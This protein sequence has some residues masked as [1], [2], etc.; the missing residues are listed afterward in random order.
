MRTLPTWLA[1]VLVLLA[2]GLARFD[3]LVVL[4]LACASGQ[5]ELAIAHADPDAGAQGEPTAPSTAQVDPN[6][7]IPPKL[8]AF[9][10]AGYPEDARAAGVSEASVTL[11]LT[12]SAEGT[13]EDASLSGTPAG[14]GFDE[15]AQSAA[16]GFVF[17]P[18]MKNGEP[19]RARI[20]YR[21]EF[22]LAPAEAEVEAAAVEQPIA[23]GGLEITIKSERNKPLKDVELLISTEADANFAL[24]L[25]TNEQGSAK[26]GQLQP[27]KYVVHISK[28]TYKAEA[29]PEEVIAGQV[30]ALSYRLTP[31]LNYEEYSATARVKAPPRE[32]TR[33]TIEREVL[34]R[35]A[36]TRGDALRTIELLP[37]VGRPP[38]GAGLVL[39]R[40][41]APQDSSVQL[42]GV[43]VPLLY[44]FGLLTSFINSRALERI[45][46]YPGNFSVKYGRH[47]GGVIDVGTRDPRTDGYHGVLD[48][49]VPLDSSL[50]VEG[51]I[52]KKAS[53]LVAGR[54]SYFG[55][56]MQAV[57]PKGTLDAFV[58]PVYNDYQL[59]VV[60]KPTNK[61]RVRL[62]V[63]GS[64]DR[65]KVLFSDA[66]DDDPTIS[67]IQIGTRFDRQ[68]IGWNH[69]YSSKLDHT[70]EIGPGRIQNDF[71]FGQDLH[72][73]LL[74][75]EIYMRGEWR[76]RI[77]P[78]LTLIFGTDSLIN[79]FK[80]QYVGPEANGN[81]GEAD[82]GSLSDR[83]TTRVN[84]SGTAY[85][86]SLYVEGAWQP[87]K[88]LRFVP[89]FRVDY[90]DRNKRFTYDPRLSAFYQFI[91]T[92]RLKLG[93]GVFSQP[94]QPQ[95]SA[96]GIG[97]PK[98]RSMRSVHYDLGFDHT[99]SDDFTLTAEG[100]YKQIYD[101]VIAT[102]TG[103]PPFSNDG[104]GRI[105]GLEVLG[106]KQATGRWFGFL[107]YTLMRSER[108]EPNAPWR[109]FDYDQRHIF[110]L[111]A[112]VRLGR[113]WETGATVRVV[114]GNPRT[115]YTKVATNYLDSGNFIGEH[116]A[117][118]SAR[119]PT[120]NR[121][122]VR[123][124]KMWTF[125]SWRLACYLDIQNIYNAKNPEGIAYSFDY[126]QSAPIRGLIIIPVLGLRGEL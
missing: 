49:N 66:G 102:P 50:L 14:Y 95:E 22:K 89:G 120:F 3:R 17:E 35:V 123:V 28:A 46:F 67:R 54:R 99:F 19:M 16:M 79:R 92:T 122:D 106:R 113:G 34:M 24:R 38:F 117:I 87:H 97:N 62:S 105:Y 23:Y 86:P 93:V 98:L 36:G 57:I 125:D 27:G 96:P 44:H 77:D 84:Q 11:V 61:D 114:T 112:G 13:V 1:L 42:D 65:L 40:G 119:N 104:K 7:L 76:Y 116:G 6:A 81:E 33:R 107:S 121:L 25:V 118:N 75:N 101:R 59:F 68:Q 109:P 2:R 45:D 103:D 48:V 85:Q 115:P 31:L 124:E 74:S 73:K 43:Q 41:A 91:P 100:F 10:D 12:I 80:V 8:K 5:F 21:Y 26:Q 56:V 58:A 55:E 83:T 37:G 18:A 70:I 63:Y 64:S 108:K 71:Y 88:L 9:I 90:N 60:Y 15:L 4:S 82:G 110:T 20:R 69:Q 52:T 78:K 32:V 111:A 72:F 47:M 39:I 94:P 126:S 30:T 53:F 51:P 29:H